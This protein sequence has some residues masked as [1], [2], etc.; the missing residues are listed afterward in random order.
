MNIITLTPFDALI[1][2]IIILFACGCKKKKVAETKPT[3]ATSK[4][5][6]LKPKTN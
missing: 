2:E 3:K 1:R 4:T 6:K 5:N